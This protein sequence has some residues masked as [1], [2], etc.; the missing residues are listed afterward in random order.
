MGEKG[1][2]WGNNKEN[3]EYRSI[4]SHN[5]KQKRIKMEKE[6][7]NKGCKGKQKGL[8]GAKGCIGSKRSKGE[9]GSNEYVYVRLKK[10]L[11]NNF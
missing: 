8:G 9:R 11:R 6:R 2:Q 3:E 4:N 5:G 7:L 1:E 10:A